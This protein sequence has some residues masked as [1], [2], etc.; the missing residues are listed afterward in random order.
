MAMNRT[1]R[2]VL[3]FHP[4]TPERLAD[5][6]RFSCAHGKFRYCSCMRWRMT[7]GEFQRSSKEQRV[8]ALAAR[9]AAGEPGGVLA[10]AEGEPIGW[11]SI[12]PREC[13]AALE[14]STVLPRLDAAPVWAVVCF[15]IDRR[16]RRKGVALDL[17][18]AA[19]AYARTKGATLIE[20]YPVEPGARSYTFMGTP[21]L[22]F[23]GGFRDVTP[24]AQ[25]RRVMR[26]EAGKGPRPTSRPQR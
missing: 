14:R 20:G 26:I 7:S 5:L 24:E 12:A 1:V 23:A 2:P 16:F 10:Y 18:H 3:E 15:F 9:V 25:V 11:C 13:Y 22:F 21:E 8:A 17:L 4:V 19:V 6:E